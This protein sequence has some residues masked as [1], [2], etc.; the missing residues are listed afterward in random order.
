MSPTIHDIIRLTYESQG[1]AVININMLGNQCLVDIIDILG[2]RTV[3]VGL[4][5]TAQNVNSQCKQ[6]QSGTDSI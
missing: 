3:L 4:L 5:L 2:L 6:I 1:I